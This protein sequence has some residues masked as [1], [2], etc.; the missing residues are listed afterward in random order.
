M[1]TESIEKRARGLTEAEKC[2]YLLEAMELKSCKEL[3]SGFLIKDNGYKNALDE[4]SKQYGSP[5]VL[6]PHYVQ[7]LRKPRI[8]M[9]HRT[10]LRQTRRHIEQHV[11]NIEMLKGKSFETFMAALAI[12]DFDD[13]LT[14]TWN[15]YKARNSIIGLPTVT[16]VL[17]FLDEQEQL[18][19]LRELD[20]PEPPTSVH[21]TTVTSHPDRKPSTTSKQRHQAKYKPSARTMKVQANSTVCPEC[22]EN[23]YINKCSTFL[24]KGTS[25][26][27]KRAKDLKLCQNCL[28]SNHTTDECRSR[29]TCKVCKKRHHSVIH[30]GQDIPIEEQRE[31]ITLRAVALAQGNKLEENKTA[32]SRAG[33]LPTAIVELRNGRQQ[34][35]VRVGFDSGAVTSLI[36]LKLAKQMKYSK[37]GSSFEIS[38]MHSLIPNFGSVNA[39][40]Y[41]FYS[42][43]YRDLGLH[44][45][46]DIPYARPPVNKLRVLDSALIKPLAPIA[47]PE[48]GGRVDILIGAADMIACST[49]SSH[50]DPENLIEARPTIFGWVI[51]T[52]V[53]PSQKA[54]TRRS[55]VQQ[56]PEDLEEV[57]QRLFQIDRISNERTMTDDDQLAVDHFMETYERHEDGRYKVKLP[58]KLNAPPLGASF[59]TAK[60]RH[61]QNER[62][63]VKKGQLERFRQV[64]DEYLELD[65]AEKVPASEIKTSK[66]T[67]YMPVHGVSKQTSTTTK[68][69]AVFDA[70][71]K[72]SNG[73][74]LN[75]TLLTGPNQ[76]PLLQNILFKFRLKS[77]GISADIG[78][79]FRQIMLHEEERDLHRFLRGTSAGVEICRMKRLTFGVK[80]SPY[81]A[82]QVIQHWAKQSL[83]TYPLAAKGILENFYVDDFLFSVDTTEQGN[84]I[85]VQLCNLLKEIGMDI[86]K[87]RTNDTELRKLIPEESLELSDLTLPKPLESSRALGIHWDVN[88]DTLHVAVPP[89]TTSNVTKREVASIAAKMYDK[90][91]LFSP[92]LI[93][94]KIILRETWKRKLDWD[95]EIP[96][97]LQK[98]WDAWMEHIHC[99]AEHPVRRSLS[100]NKAVVL[101]EL[102][103]FA[104]ASKEAYG[105]VTYLRTTYDDGS[106]AINLLYSQGRVVPVRANTIPRLELEALTLLAKQLAYIREIMDIDKQYV[107]AWSDSEIVLA[108]TKKHPSGLKTYVGNR[109]QIIQAEVDVQ[110]CNHVSSK[111]NPA[112]LI[113]RGISANKLVNSDLWWHGPAWLTSKAEA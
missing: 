85:R 91:G 3:V 21:N 24:R 50:I 78:K 62:S 72:T 5:Q 28:M 49:G 29:F 93:P 71:A 37:L 68:L 88:Q 47:D 81:I 105:A 80:S 30:G 111:D 75:E 100:D 101:R 4:L 10:S 64:I 66:P 106:V 32:E 41:S 61:F 52:E 25:D 1:F 96:D 15:D 14:T 35:R 57:L 45:V 19:P 40:L 55:T 87:W 20:Q 65:H 6:Y 95:Q 74:S 7:Q 77:I 12:N 58:H 73:V 22:G 9:K 102:H 69:R 16:H 36:S 11:D 34:K 99:I 110:N 56:E 83:E 86:R 43:D 39:R 60:R 113:S 38:G 26:R 44:I 42:D 17:N 92:A 97:D 108:W 53:E 98:N 31:S 2:N 13:D 33:T 82:T 67:F 103:G 90:L 59:Q 94:A 79:M 48:L 104:D 23:H 18:R 54:L 109:V 112:D 8:T 27:W 89:R 63:L 107:Y 46:K 70:S 51:T 84:A 76:Y